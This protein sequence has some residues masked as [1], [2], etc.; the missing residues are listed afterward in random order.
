MRRSRALLDADPLLVHVIDVGVVRR[1]RRWRH[2]RVLRS[3]LI[4][5]I[6]RQRLIGQRS[7]VSHRVVRHSGFRHPVV[8]QVGQRRIDDRCARSVA[9]VLS[10]VAEAIVGVALLDVAA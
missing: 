6:V 8:G 2:R 1:C 9:L 3:N 10:E 5:G 7:D 4:E